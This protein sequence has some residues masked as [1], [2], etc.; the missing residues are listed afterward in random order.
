MGLHSPRGE[1]LFGRQLSR[2]ASRCSVRGRS[3]CG[4]GRG[5]GVSRGVSRSG[6]RGRGS[7]PRAG[8]GSSRSVWRSRMFCLK[9][10]HLAFFASLYF[11]CGSLCSPPGRQFRSRGR[12]VSPF[13][14]RA[15]GASPRLSS[16]GGRSRHGRWP[17]GSRSPSPSPSARAA[18]RDSHSFPRSNHIITA[19]GCFSFKRFSVGWSSSA[20]CAR[21]AVGWLSTRMVQY[22]W[23]GGIPPSYVLPAR[24]RAPADCTQSAST[25]L[26]WL[27]RTNQLSGR[28]H[29]ST[30]R[31]ALP[32]KAG[33]SADGY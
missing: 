15:G 16:R 20:S 4:K 29:C 28:L 9:R 10:C 13:A 3:A 7:S 14:S 32:E 24:R 33:V 11:C 17:G 18:S 2:G 26:I 1:S 6:G 25:H 30:I 23:R 31:R 12:P 27:N 8:R 22:A 19:D 21:K 5:S